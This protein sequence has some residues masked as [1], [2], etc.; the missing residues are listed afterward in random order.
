MK[1]LQLIATAVFIFSG[2]VLS[3]A[4]N[5]VMG[6]VSF[7]QMPLK[8]AIVSHIDGTTGVRTNKNG[9][10][11][12]FLHQGCDSL[13]VTYPGMKTVKVA[14]NS[15]DTIN[16]P[17]VKIV[18]AET[19]EDASVNLRFAKS[20]SIM[21]GAAAAPSVTYNSSHFNLPD[22]YNT[23]SYAIE[24]E[25]I[26]KDAFSSPLS[27]FSADVDRA[28]YTNI[29]RY[30]NNGQRPP[31]GAIR[32]EEMVNYF[33]YNFHSSNNDKPVNVHTEFA[34]CPWNKD[35]QLVFIGLQGK[36]IPENQLMPSNLVFLIDVSGSM[37]S[38]NKL[39]LVKSSLKMLIKKL[40]DQDKIAIVT[41]AGNAKIHLPSTSGDNKSAISEA[42]DELTA[43]GSTAGGDGLNLAYSLASD[44]FIE[45]GNNRIIMAT[46]GDFNMGETSDAAMKKLVIE[47]AKHGVYMTVLGFGMGNYKDSKLEAIANNGNGNYAYI[48]NATE[49]HK[50][51]VK[52]FSGT[53]YT[54]AKDLKIQIEF[55]P[56]WVKSYRLI[57]YENRKLENED[58]K[59]DDK[60]AGEI[61]AGHQMVALYEIVPNNEH[62]SGNNH[63]KYQQFKSI[64]NK[65]DLLSCSI[66][67][68]DIDTNN[69][70]ENK[71]VILQSEY[72]KVPSSN[73]L[74]AAAVAEFGMILN[75]SKFKK[76]ASTES[77]R[78]ML[79][80]IK[81]SDVYGYSGELLKLVETYGSLVDL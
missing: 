17:M 77:I 54:I 11:E 38:A 33:S 29:R 44:N 16:I 67:Y 79:L 36:E 18:Y 71:E 68:R 63:L 52:E 80:S 31:E 47:Q 56:Y 26:F 6:T 45:K 25:N 12:L 48:D 42:I 28:S 55:N 21:M 1:T 9:I 76:D 69:M 23:E 37:S 66:R 65:K 8:G 35:N 70:V 22:A 4:Q 46:D 74:L 49:A 51:L 34:Q 14:I 19:E 58:F 57:G 40:R 41:Y 81:E 24:N 7:N 60:D 5:K 15:R 59:N 72:T 61:G 53:L 13:L 27:T 2:I 39:P 43:G 64:D 30:L 20:K 50:F 10:Y 62:H 78:E 73:F 3:Q 32:I 75:D